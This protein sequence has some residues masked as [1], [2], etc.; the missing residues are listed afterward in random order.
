MAPSTS[1]SAIALA[2]AV[3]AGPTVAA[4]EP[5]RLR[6]EAL[7]TVQAPAGL[8]TLE[9]RDRARPWLDAEASIWFGAGDDTDADALVMVV[10]LRDPK[11]RGS[12]RLGRQ[13]IVAGALRPIHLDGADTLVRVTRNASVEAFAGIPVEP[14]F[15]ARSWDWVTGARAAYAIGKGSVGVAWQQRRDHGAL[16]THEL[17][18]DGGMPIGKRV[19]VGAGVALDLIDTGLAEARVSAAWRGKRARAEL[20]ATQRSPSHLLPATSLFSVLGD[21]PATRTGATGRWR[22][23]PRLDVEGSLALRIADGEADEDL[24]AGTRLKLDDRGASSLGLELRRQGSP[25]GGWFG[26]RGMHRLGLAEDWAFSTEVEIV[27]PDDER[28]RGS[29]WPWGLAAI[30]WRPASGWEVAGAVES[31]SSPQYNLRVDALVRLSR[32]WDAEENAAPKL[33]RGVLAR[34]G[35]P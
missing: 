25:D 22:A 30:S 21:V 23:A 32:A 19:D 14:T 26:V 29:V 2:V 31:S 8:M 15:A 6:G 12:L 1:A 10:K 3:A 4:A 34:G 16:A 27:V 33:A 7:A 5:L 24:A 18:A 9:G 17:A 11:R 35:E 28:G 20:F 13:I